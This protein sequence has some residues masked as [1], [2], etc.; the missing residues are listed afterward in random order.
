MSDFQ[1]V[2]M[3]AIAVVITCLLDFAMNILYA[4][5]ITS[6]IFINVIL[7]M[8][9]IVTILLQFFSWFFLMNLISEV[10]F[11]GY[12]RAFRKFWPI[13]C[14]TIAYFVFFIINIIIQFIFVNEGDD[15]Y[16]LWNNG[17]IMA[18]WSLQRIVSIFHY[19]FSLY[20]VIR[21]LSDSSQFL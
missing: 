7:W 6:S 19:T 10:R 2:K 16:D 15:I 5:S 12:N 13:F 18:F 9:Q 17:A 8:S 1:M 3:A 4:P 21:L 14:S 11:G 20:Y